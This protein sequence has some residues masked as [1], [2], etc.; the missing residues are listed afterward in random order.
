MPQK[1]MIAGGSG[2]IGQYLSEHF[3]K[4]GDDIIVLSRSPK[5]RTDGI[6]SVYWDGEHLGEWAT[7]L[8]GADVLINL[9]GKSVDCRYTE[10]NKQAILD[11][12]IKS[13]MVLGKA[14]QQAS[15]PPSIWFN[16]STATIYRHSE[17][18][19]MTEEGEFGDGFSEQVAK[20]WEQTFFQTELPQTR[21]IALRMSF[22]L[23][24]GSALSTLTQLAK[25]GLGGSQGKGN[26]YVSW[27]HIQ[28]LVGMMEFL[29]EKKELTGSFNISSPNP[30]PN[31]DFMKQLRKVLGIPFGLPATPWMLELGAWLLQTETELITKSRRV[32]PDRLMKA[33][34]SLQFPHL[35]EALQD[36]L[37]S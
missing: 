9:A 16:S 18:K 36:L 14:I 26:Q 12:R 21:R 29:M 10:A 2:F 17:D 27:L 15:S 5:D 32:V 25:A 22:I 34:Y 35:E 3:R 11:S 13:T 20:S 23:G 24:D 7:E 30:I 19:D 33:G 4:K 1:I 8:D 37:L 6:R 31:R 28:D